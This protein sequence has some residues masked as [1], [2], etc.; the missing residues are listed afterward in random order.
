MNNIA[1]FNSGDK[2]LQVVVE[3]MSNEQ[4]TL[5]QKG[6]FAL[7]EVWGNGGAKI[8]HL[9]EYAYSNTWYDC[10]YAGSLKF[11][12]QV[13][14]NYPTTS[15]T[16]LMILADMHTQEDVVPYLNADEL[17]KYGIKQGTDMN[18]SSGFTK[19]MLK[20]GMFVLLRTQ[21]QYSKGYRLVLNDTFTYESGHLLVDSYNDDLT[22]TFDEDFDV[23]EVFTSEN[24][25]TLNQKSLR[26]SL[27]SIW[28][29][30]SPEELQ[31]LEKKAELEKAILDA[32]EQ[33][34]IA[35]EALAE[36]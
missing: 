3:G 9:G 27:T 24:I 4:K 25:T 34:K 15:F 32:E 7:G 26:D 20:D 36:L 2:R 17:I 28:K 33:I 16:E 18:T 6:F 29:R 22:H 35:K 19:N 12:R 13:D 21:D 31:R 14:H 1:R 8:Q 10:D 11:I 23:V 30:Q 5:V